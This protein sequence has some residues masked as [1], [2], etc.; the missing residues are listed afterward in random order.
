MSFEDLTGID[1][2]V[3]SGGAGGKIE[4]RLDSPTG[5]LAG[6][7]GGR[8]RRAAGRTGPTSRRRSP[9]PP[10]GTHELFIVFTH[11]TDHGGLF[12]LNWFR[13]T[14]RA[15]RTAPPPEV[16][17]TAEPATGNAPLK[18]QFNATA[19]DR[20]EGE[21]LTYL[22]DF[23]VTGTH[24]RHVDP[25]GPDLH[26]R[27]RRHL[28]GQGHRDRPQ[29]IGDRDG[30]G[31]VTGAPNQC[32]QNAKSDEFNGTG[33]DINRWTVIRPAAATSDRLGR[34]A[35]TCRSTTARSTRAAR[36]PGTSS[37]SRT[38]SGV[39]TVT[40]K[41]TTDPLDRELPAGR[42]ARVLRRRQLGV[43]AHDLRGRRRQFEFIYE[44]AG[45]P[46]NEAADNSAAPGRRAADL[47]RAGSTRTARS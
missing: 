21:A 3:A 10:Q 35:R 37:P 5:P 7:V 9:T 47:L 32:P 41:I 14:A 46:R 36:R 23:G 6:S 30:R 2:R 44:N 15:R 28:H 12:N 13:S 25:G 17:A 33:L 22:W 24:D 34:Q 20:T 38:P 42:P 11:P 16:T 31:R 40:A 45:N 8:H 26:L 4:L 18:V 39:W 1:F 27:Q 19:T 29:G 43:G